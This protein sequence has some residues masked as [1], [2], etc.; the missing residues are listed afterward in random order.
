M[1]W[2]S[3]CHAARVF[4]SAAPGNSSAPLAAPNSFPIR[5]FNRKRFLWPLSGCDRLERRAAIRPIAERASHGLTAARFAT[6]ISTVRS[7]GGFPIS[8]A[9][10]LWQLHGLPEHKQ[11]HVIEGPSSGHAPSTESCLFSANL[12]KEDNLIP[13]RRTQ[14]A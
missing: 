13:A 12:L 14:A 1:A 8:S 9:E 6:L 10:S 3:S 5:S 4:A 2:F 7:A 11:R